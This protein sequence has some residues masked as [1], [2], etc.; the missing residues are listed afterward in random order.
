MRI[1]LLSAIP[2]D[3]F[4]GRSFGAILGVINGG[5]GLGGL[6]GP[7][8]GGYLFDR[9]DSYRVAFTVAALAIIASAVAAWIAV[10]PPSRARGVPGRV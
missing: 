2:A 1:S 10:R 3:Q 7:W 4:R 9:T 6:I 5:G 8:L